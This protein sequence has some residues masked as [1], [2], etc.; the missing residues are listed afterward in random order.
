MLPKNGVYSL[1]ICRTGPVCLQPLLA[2]G[3][4]GD[5]DLLE[6]LEQQ[7]SNP[8]ALHPIKRI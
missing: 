8:V 4:V 3:E 7:T 2:I 5:R 6:I 1:P